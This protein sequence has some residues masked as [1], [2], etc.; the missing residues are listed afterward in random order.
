MNQPHSVFIVYNS[1]TSTT[2]ALYEVNMILDLHNIYAQSADLGVLSR[3]QGS[4]LLS[5][6][7]FI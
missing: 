6:D 7:L 4:H 3:D 1:E 2:R 5:S